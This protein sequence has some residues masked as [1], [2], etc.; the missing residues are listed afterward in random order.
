M[1]CVNN[2]SCFELFKGL[3]ER[4][5]D[6]M[7]FRIRKYQNK[8]KPNISCYRPQVLSDNGRYVDIGSSVGYTTI[9]E[10]KSF[11]LVYKTKV[12][13]EVVEEFEL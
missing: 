2:V 1:G 4:S 3:K 5:V 10:A 7:K 12:E 13:S 11:C 9:E 6:R 8:L